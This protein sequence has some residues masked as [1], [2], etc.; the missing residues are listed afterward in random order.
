MKGSSLHRF[1]LLAALC[2][3]APAPGVR[4]EGRVYDDAASVEP[5]PPGSRVPAVR[6]RSVDSEPV[7]LSRLVRDRGALLVFY[8]GGW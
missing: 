7:E 3:A 8:R 4:A 6:V 2:V 1:A 5:L